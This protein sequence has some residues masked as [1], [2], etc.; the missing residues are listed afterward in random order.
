MQK[1]EETLN[2]YDTEGDKLVERLI[3]SIK[4]GLD[5][6]EK[7]SDRQDKYNDAKDIL[8][9]LYIEQKTKRQC[10]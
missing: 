2:N 6:G 4:I 7:I 5:T 3:K 8:H 9:F 1:W 10:N